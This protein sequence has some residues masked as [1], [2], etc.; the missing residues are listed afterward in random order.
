MQ[1]ETWLPRLLFK[2][3]KNEIFFFIFIFCIYK[4]SYSI[5]NIYFPIFVN[6][7]LA[8]FISI[9]SVCRGQNLDSVSLKKKYV[10]QVKH[11]F[12]KNEEPIYFN[13]AV[14]CFIIQTLPDMP[15]GS[16]INM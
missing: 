8:K 10:I 7:V 15:E 9:M 6:L 14:I 2:T 4:I 11:N 12:M 16:G 13:K 1:D 5:V 3:T